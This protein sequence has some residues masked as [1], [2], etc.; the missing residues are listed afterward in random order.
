MT[1]APLPTSGRCC[2]QSLTLAVDHTKYF[3]VEINSKGGGWWRTFS[4]EEESEAPEAVRLFCPDCGEYFQVPK[5][6][7]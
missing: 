1:L 7:P 5:G 3:V 2:G 6:L 4:H